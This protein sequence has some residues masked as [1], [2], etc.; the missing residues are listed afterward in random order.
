LT[1]NGSNKPATGLSWEETA[2]FVN[3]LN[4][5]RGLSPAYKFVGNTLQVWTSSDS[6]YDASNPFRNKKANYFIPSADEWN[7]AAYYDPNKGGTGIGGYWIYPTKTDSPPTA[8]S[9]GNNNATAVYMGQTGPADVNLAGGIGPYGTYGQ[10]G[11]ASEALETASDRVNNTA[12][13]NRLV[14][15]GFW[16]SSESDWPRLK[17]GYY[18]DR[19]T[20]GKGN[21]PSIGFRVVRIAQNSETN[22]QAY[23]TDISSNVASG[24]TV[25]ASSIY[26][27][28]YRA[29]QTVNGST[30]ETASSSWFS[31]DS[32]LPAWILIDL[33]QSYPISGLSILN[34]INP[35]WNDTG[36]KDITVQASENGTTYTTVIASTALAWQNVGFQ[37]K[38]F[39]TVINARYI[40]ITVTSAYGSYARAGLNEVKVVSPAALPPSYLLITSFDQ[41][42]GS[43]MVSPNQATYMGEQVTI[44]A[45]PFPGYVFTSW[46][47]DTIG[48]TATVSFTMDTDITIT[49]NFSQDTSDNDADRVSNYQEI[50][51]YGSNPNQKDSNGD[52]VEDGDAVSMGYNPTLNFSALIAH[53]PTGLYTASQMQAMAIGDLVLTKNANGSFVLNYDIEKS[54][55][56]QSWLPYQSLNLTLT[57]LPPDKAFIRIKAKQ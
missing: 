15:G 56:L 38:P 49:A 6:G 47:G 10:G 44:T 32:T 53:P 25:T 8:V 27:T 48:N 1:G 12:D 24:K 30:S 43:I 55:D 16:G 11:N 26:S 46:S 7:K 31:K 45:S 18:G 28:Q 36:A 51:T 35:P 17:G 33:G 52:G 9:S 39:G 2:K 4:T 41:S 42:K 29:S 57:N 5:S 20:S 50:V 19:D 37:D 13:E 54:T 14:A 22:P 34:A 3:Y 21:Y 23:S 40:K